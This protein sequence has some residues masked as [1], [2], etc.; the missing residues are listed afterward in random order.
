MLKS[1]TELEPIPPQFHFANS[2]ETKPPS[3]SVYGAGDWPRIAPVWT[4][5]A[6]ASPHRSFYLSADWIAA[7]MDTFGRLLKP[8]IL[9]FEQ[10][11]QSIGVCLLIR[12]VERRGPF[13]VSRIYLNTGGESP[14]DRTLM[15]FNNILCQPGKEEGIAEA[16]GA[17]LQRLSWD[18]FA[19]QGIRPGAV[20]SSLQSKTFPTL[21]VAVTLRQTFTVDLDQLRRTSKS[22]LDSVSANSR[23]QIRRSIKRYGGAAVIK[24]EIARDVATAETFFAEMCRMHQSRWLA[25]GKE[26]AFGPGRRLDFHRALVRRAYEKGSIHLLRVSADE[27]TVGILYNFVQD[28]KIYFFQSGFNYKHDRRLKPGLVTHAYAIQHYLDAGF[29][30]YDFLAGDARYKASLAKERGELA[31]VVFARPSVKGASIELL[32]V[33]KRRMKGKK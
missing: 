25:R 17:Y 3:V 11:G 24:V 23:G 7:W 32:R 15:E 12:M 19:I 18:E 33:L 30:E 13:R 2:G 1:A 5:L 14:A 20:L 9:V 10:D 31:W 16:L 29:S 28:R 26:G 21:P 6:G 22:Y 8:R 27:E 4:E